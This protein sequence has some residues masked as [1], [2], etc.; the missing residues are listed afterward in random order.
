MVLGTSDIHVE[1]KFSKSKSQILDIG[2]EAVKYAKTLLPDIQY[3]TEDASR[4]DF[5]YL[6]ATIEAVIKAGATMINVLDTVG[7]AELEQFGELIY[8]LNDRIKIVNHDVFF[9]INF[10]NIIYK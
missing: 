9:N 1:K 10:H 3:S 4:C 5:E 7:F 2:V 8:K 6:W